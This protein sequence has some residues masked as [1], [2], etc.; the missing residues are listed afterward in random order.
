MTTAKIQPT[1]EEKRPQILSGV[2]VSNKMKDTAVVMI[3]RYVKHPKYHKFMTRRTKFLAHD[4]GN[5]KKI[6][7][8]A[9]IQAC[10]PMSKRKS[11]IVIS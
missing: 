2:V 4:A 11:F 8:K 9:T 3:E 5:S 10:R 1:I 6:G 7:E